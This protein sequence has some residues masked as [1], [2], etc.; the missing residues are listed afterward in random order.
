MSEHDSR[1]AS[2]PT[3][4]RPTI[5]VVGLGNMGL[6]IA[7]RLT[8]RF[9]VLGADL[10]A[11]R[12]AEAQTAGVTTLD[13]ADLL[14]RC[15]TVVLSLPQPRASLGVARQIAAAPGSVVRVV[16]TS[17]VTP[18]DAIAEKAVLNPAGVELLEA[19]VLSGV[20]QMRAGTAGLVLAGDAEHLAQLAPVFDSL[21]SDQRVLGA[22]GTAMAA[23]VINNAVA[24]VVMVVLAEAVAMAEASQLDPQVVVDLLA[25]PSGGLMRPLTHRVG[26][27]VF[28]GDYAGGMSL[29][30]AR[31]DS[32]LAQQLAQDAGLPLFTVPAAHGVYEMAIA[33]GWARED[34]A[35]LVK[36]W[37]QWGQTSFVQG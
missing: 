30:A 4:E 32:V 25:A 7:E 20:A 34:Y 26:E 13:L 10:S 24:H 3:G 5:G 12:R 9:V 16:E 18:A 37:E 17:T 8:S 23:K 1:S 15:E 22:T 11:E 29:E 31:K 35:A 28:T 36:L 27:R 19:A 6:A 21:T 33:A 14:P 2:E